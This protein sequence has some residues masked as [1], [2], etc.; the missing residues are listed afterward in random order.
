LSL[1]PAPPT[2]RAYPADVKILALEGREFI[3]VGTAHIS[4]RSVDLVRQ[5]IEQ[6]K[7][8]VVCVE[9]DSQRYQALSE[10]RKW[11][12]LD[13]K[14]VIRK[15]QLSTLLVNLL[16]AAYQKR[17]GDKLGV[18]PGVELL[19]ATQV[20]K[21]FDIPIEL[22]DRD[23]RIT[24]RRA[25]HSMSF[26]EKAKLLASGLVGVLE[27]HEISEEELSRLREQDV[28][29]ELM[30]ELGRA[31]PI[32]K[33][34]L[35]DERDTYLTQKMKE[36]EGRKVVA[37][38]GAGHVN[39][40]AE[41]LQTKGPVDL[42]E[43]EKIP[44]V[45]PIWKWIGWGIPA[46]ILG[47]LV[48]IGWDQGLK[49]AGDNLLYWIL[50]NGIPSSIGAIIA[51]AHPIT[52]ISAFIAAPITSLTPVIGAGYVCAFIQAYYQPPVVKE[53]QTVIDDVGTFSKWWSN[54]LLRI[55]LVF[56]LTSFGSAIGTYVGAYEIVS[57]LF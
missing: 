16:L 7:P 47:S 50:A 5:V 56:I 6:E 23:V 21:E 43:I 36:A 10:Q 4:Q 38:V 27:E 3:L 24:L 48:Y 14:E 33:N 51:F 46:L 35:I 13:L 30:S 32:L 45:L 11:E 54:K 44:P 1:K 55:L 18:M 26:M 29:S 42:T 2:E 17:L 15:Q 20:A 49:A 39:G 22:C 53:F 37:V 40:I 52:I 57:N 12:A 9:L 28:L 41:A 31:M 19:E 25:W 34:V 8:D